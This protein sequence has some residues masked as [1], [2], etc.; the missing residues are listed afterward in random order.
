[1]STKEN[2]LVVHNAY[3]QPGGE[4][5]VVAS[6]IS[7]LRQR[8]HVVEEF[9]RCN[10]D[11]RGSNSMA[12]AAGTVWSRSSFSDFDSAVRTFQ[13]D[14]IHVHNTFPL[15][16]PSVYWLA[17]RLDVPVVQSL[18]NFRLLCP[19]GTFLRKGAVCESCLGGAPLLGVLRGCYRGSR[20]QTAVL[21]G[22]LVAHRVLGTWQNKI[23]RYIALNEF[24]RQKFIEGGLPAGRITIK[25]NFVDLPEIVERRRSGFLF[26]GRLSPEKGIE[27]LVRAA[28]AVPHVSLRVAGIGPMMSLLDGI[29]N[30]AALRALAAEDVYAEMCNATALVLPSICYE[31]FPRTLVEAYAC[32]LP[33][34]ASR[35]G[36]LPSLVEEGVTGLLFRSGDAADFA[37]KIRWAHQ[38]PVRMAE[39]GQAA[40]LKYE[41]E[42]TPDINYQQLMEIYA[43]AIQECKFRTV[44]ND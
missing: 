16:S 43:D 39:M 11:I 4:D 17:A 32:S 19:Q 21:A 5:T 30:I 44:G 38:N 10:N 3:Q 24:C 8:G 18:H 14:I 35:I 9:T 36:S 29:A 6:E 28:V 42:F 37:S 13:P 27:V 26:V 40:R 23:A 41:A 1:M 12:L 25:P 2:V 22:M 33:V 31:S 20:S 15:I 34:I 7:L